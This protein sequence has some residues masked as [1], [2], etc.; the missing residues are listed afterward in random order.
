MTE[1]LQKMA[2][3][4]CAGILDPY[5]ISGNIAATKSEAQRA[6]ALASVKS[7]RDQAKAALSDERNGRMEDALRRWDYVFNYKLFR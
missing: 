5:R 1:M 4:D 6:A 3:R 7:S 2:E